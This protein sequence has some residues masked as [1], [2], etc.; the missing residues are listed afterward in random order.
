MKHLY[1]LLIGIILLCASV[2]AIPTTLAAT[3]IGNNNATLNMA[4]AVGDAW[5]NVGTAPG[6]AWSQLPNIT[7]TSYTWIGSPI[8]G[9]TLYYFKA[10]DSTGCDVELSFTT[11]TV[12]PIPTGTYGRW[13]QNITEQKFNPAN[14]VW[15][16][17]QAYISVTGDTVFYGIL[18]IMLFVG[19]WLSTRG[20]S[21]GQQFGMIMVS[22]FCVA[23]A[24]LALGLPPELL[25]VGQA[26][27]Y[28][29]LAAAVVSFTVK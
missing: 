9:N 18:F 22:L 16:G 24:G 4:G 7:G 26:L 28:I 10:C 23:G 6:A 20:T 8:Y 12:T 19:L 13:A 29:S 27:L 21:M 2:S 3:A 17:L 14:V 15:N 1:L 25:A 5:F 11:T